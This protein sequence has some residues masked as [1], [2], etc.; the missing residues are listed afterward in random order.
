MSDG[1]LLQGQGWGQSMGSEHL[2]HELW[3]SATT[4]DAPHWG[5]LRPVLIV[6]ICCV[7]WGQEWCLVTCVTLFLLH[8][9]KEIPAY[10]E[11]SPC[12]CRVSTCVMSEAFLGASNLPLCWRW[13]PSGLLIPEPPGSLNL[14][15][16][17]PCVLLF[18][19]KSSRPQKYFWTRLCLFSLGPVLDALS[20]SAV[21]LDSC[22]LPAW[23]GLSLAASL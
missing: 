17:E 12:P 23:T 19:T 1:A 14:A 2:I 6:V 9:K 3:P 4:K 10:K 16:C 5:D 22:N 18:G 20:N 13:Y 7:P 21:S 11:F 15:E 8:F